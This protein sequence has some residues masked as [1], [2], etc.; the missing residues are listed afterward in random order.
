MGSLD[1]VRVISGRML[2]MA[3]ALV[4]VVNALIKAR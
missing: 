1:T 3:N 2:Y 4:T